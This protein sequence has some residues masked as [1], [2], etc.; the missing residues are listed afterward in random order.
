MKTTAIIIA[1]MFAIGTSFAQLT[2]K[3]VSEFVPTLKQGQKVFVPMQYGKF[4]FLDNEQL[5]AI[6]TKSI[7]KVE[8]VC[9]DHPKGYDLTAL[10]ANRKKE[11][12]AA[13]PQL[14]QNTN[15]E[16]AVIK[17]TDCPTRSKAEKMYHGLVITYASTANRKE[18]L[19]AFEV[20]FKEQ[21]IHAQSGGTVELSASNSILTIPAN[22][23]VDKN[24]N[25]IKGNVTIQYR[26]YRDAGAIAFSSIPMNYH[27]NGADVNFNSAGMFEIQA[28]HQNEEV[29]IKDGMSASMDYQITNRI[30]GLD[31]YALDDNQEWQQINKIELP[32]LKEEDDAVQSQF[33]EA[34]SEQGVEIIEE[35]LFNKIDSMVV[36]QVEEWDVRNMKAPLDN[37]DRIN[38]TLL[39]EGAN[40]GHTYPKLVKGLKMSG[41]GV[42]NCDQIYRLPNRVNIMAN[43]TDQNGNRINNL[44]VISMIDLNYNGAFSFDPDYFTCDKKGRNVILL[45]TDDNKLYA[46]NET[47]FK[48]MDIERSGKYE[49]V[50]TEITDKVKNAKDLKDYLGLTASL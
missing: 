19:S 16:Y 7:L 31:F 13:L 45:F 11:L 32:L 29:F 50:M 18:L 20:P 23:L 39:A 1:A 17:Q 47:A 22:A 3:S 27:H 10:N 9:T 15:I 49:F 30:D 8:I 5:K 43:Y 42:Y 2:E 48:K 14:N 38:G 6:D 41:F 33:G 34:N 25:N 26:E 46:I 28:Q 36:E 40:K 4:N 24:G 35:A 44:N 21:T 37:K 12:I